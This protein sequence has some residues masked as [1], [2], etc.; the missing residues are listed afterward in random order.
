MR[1]R[2]EF[3]AGRMNKGSDERIVPESQYIDAMNIRVNSAGDSGEIGAVQNVQGSK[4]LSALEFAGIRLSFD[5]VCLGAFADDANE[6][7]YWFVHDPGGTN[8]TGAT[9]TA[10]DMIISYNMSTDQ[11]LYHAISVSVLNFSASHLINGINKVGDLLFFTDDFNPPRR[12]NVTRNYPFPS[13]SPFADNVDEDDFS[14]IQKPP[15]S[16]PVVSTMSTGSEENFIEDKF[17]CF[18][19]R[20]RYKDGEYSALSQ[21]SEVAFQAN[22]F[23]FDRGTYD[24]DGCTNKHNA[25]DVTFNTGTDNVSDIQLCFKISGTNTIHV[26]QNYD[27]VEF[28][29]AD[30]IDHTIVFD[31]SKIYT[32]IPDSQLLRMFDNVP[33]LAKAQTVIGGRLVYGNYVDGF[34]LVD[35]DGAKIKMTY[36]AERRELFIGT[37]KTEADSEVSF[38]NLDYNISGGAVTVDNAQASIDF[39]NQDLNQ[40][41]FFRLLFNFSRAASPI[42]TYVLTSSEPST[43]SY[44]MFFQLPKDYSSVYDL[45]NSPEFK[46]ALGF[47]ITSQ[48]YTNIANIDTSKSVTD[49]NSC[50]VTGNFTEQYMCAY[51]GTRSRPSMSIIANGIE[52]IGTSISSLVETRQIQVTP[53][54][55]NNDVTFKFPAF[56]LNHSSLDF[57]EYFSIASMD[58]VASAPETGQKS[59]HSNRDYE[60]GIVY[61]DEYN[62]SSTVL[63]SQNNNFFISAGNNNEVNGARVRIPV[64][65]KPPTWASKYKFFMKS[66]GGDYDTIY[67]DIVFVDDAN[68]TAYFRLEG[69]N[70]QKMKEG[71]RLIVKSDSAGAVDNLIEC[72]VLGVESFEE[73]GLPVSASSP[74]GLYMSIKPD[75]DFDVSSGV[76]TLKII[77]PDAVK[78][79]GQGKQPVLAF[80]LFET[81]GADIAITAGSII[82][83]K[84][85]HHR[86]GT[87]GNCDGFFDEYIMD[88]FVAQSDYANFKDFFDNHLGGLDFDRFKIASGEISLDSHY[89]P[90]I[91]DSINDGGTNNI[92]GS[93]PIGKHE[94]QFVRQSN[95]GLELH[96]R[97]GLK[98]CLVG[99][100]KAKSNG[101]IKI[102]KSN[103][104]FIFETKAL[105]LNNDIYFE[106]NQTFDVGVDGASKRIHK[107]NTQ[108][109]NTATSAD[110]ICDLNFFNCIMFSN[111]AESMRIR[112][113]ITDNKITLGERV[114]TVAEKEFKEIDRFASLTYSGV[115]IEETGLNKLNEFNLGVANFQDL[116]KSLG[117][118][119]VIQDIGNDLLILQEDRVSYCLIDKTLVTTSSGNVALNAESDIFLGTQVARLEEFGISR[120][121]ESFARHGMDYF[122][123]DTKRGAVIRLAG[124]SVRDMEMLEV[125]KIGLRSF[126]RDNLKENINKQHIGAFDED[127]DEYV[128]TSTDTSLP[129]VN[130]IEPCDIIIQREITTSRAGDTI[131]T[132]VDLGD[133]VGPVTVE[134]NISDLAQFVSEGSSTANPNQKT[135]G[136]TTSSSANKLIDSNAKFGETVTVN[137]QVRMTDGAGLATI[138]SIDSDTQLTLSSD[139]S[140]SGRRYEVYAFAEGRKLI[141]TNATFAT[142]GVATND[143][144]VNKTTGAVGSVKSVTSETEIIQNGGGVVKLGDEYLIKKSSTG[145]ITPT[146]TWNGSTQGGSGSAK[147]STSSFAFTK[148][149]SKPS[150]M[151]LSILFPAKVMGN[152]VVKAPCPEPT[153]LNVVYVVLN[154]NES[155][156]QQVGYAFSR[157][158]SGGYSDLE[159][160]QFVL[161]TGTDATVVSS[162]IQKAGL[163]GE[164]VIPVSGDTIRMAAFNNGS[165]VLDDMT[166]ADP[167]HRFRILET[168]TQYTASQI[169]TILANS[170]LKPPT[171]ISANSAGDGYFAN[172]N[173]VRESGENYLYLIWDLRNVNRPADFSVV[174]PASS[175][176]D[177][178]NTVCCT[179]G[180]TQ[181]YIDADDPLKVNGVFTDRDLANIAND[182]LYSRGNGV[183]YHINGGQLSE[184]VDCPTC[185]TACATSAS[186]PFVP[187]Q[188]VSNQELYRLPVELGSATGAVTIRIKP[189]VDLSGALSATDHA[190][191]MIASL[192]ANTF[193]SYTS[194]V[195]GF[196]QKFWSHNGKIA[197]LPSSG[198]ASVP[199]TVRDFNGSSYTN[200]GVQSVLVDTSEVTAATNVAEYVMIVPKTSASPSRL[201]LN[202]FCVKANLFQITASCATALPS[203][204]GFFNASSSVTACAG[205]PATTFYHSTFSG[206]SGGTPVLHDIIFTNS[207]GST[208]ASAGFYKV[209]TDV[210][211]VDSNGVVTNKAGC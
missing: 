4:R 155:D 95:G 173:Y 146:I 201:L 210:L 93:D 170:E 76:S 10:V 99:N 119:M 167:V 156:D 141:D 87:N 122:F 39:T 172:F 55:G 117:E 42:S 159:G 71:D 185:A 12:I 124:S 19:Y 100:K 28:G 54:L 162:F 148:S 132:T 101:V 21:F 207:N 15:S 63:T 115:F 135:S 127:S 91:G 125:S 43:F 62:R 86:D 88:D 147:S 171:S 182:G 181:L 179:T 11:L 204:T 165:F 49:N 142:D 20:F 97:T 33:R 174:S 129:A 116:D 163:P 149:A 106:G 102:Q 46:N 194:S 69:D 153:R 209:G 136:T 103:G 36:T 131:N 78:T 139:I 178:L 145:S 35:S 52:A 34:D 200:D 50:N 59:L 120:N 6:T 133:A 23:N 128:L 168:S 197:P 206:G 32:A 203:F 14:V 157:I 26:V 107:G 152:F 130:V 83:M 58:Y 64:T 3:T 96:T 199:F 90:S 37:T 144:I 108:D 205:T 177:N 180:S 89:D 166:A 25:V 61:M 191:M 66:S 114:M 51:E 9:T 45:F 18:A 13:G 111:G 211:T 183:A 187:A 169:Q 75:G 29:L 160:G 80:E 105:E 1:E 184:I 57:F 196:V 7:I 30:N 2:R 47:D 8:T 72:T 17:I 195:L 104:T 65:Q 137:D 53:T 150:T 68:G 118:V 126:F 16:A 41:A 38:S 70:K 134:V 82:S 121:P 112:D 176:D 110:A 190:G 113:R 60:V 79:T 192:G 74:S 143:V 40:G 56:K 193:N 5:T 67:S 161:G 31:N 138:S 81:G 24:N 198:S 85:K 94:F 208:R 27:K 109:Q 154:S 164:G 44:E 123:A 84:I 98:G 22:K 175:F 189:N 158:E 151:D 48:G 186:T 202:F 77:D 92:F 188:V 140:L 73:D